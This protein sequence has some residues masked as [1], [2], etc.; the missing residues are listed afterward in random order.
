MRDLE[1]ETLCEWEMI[2]TQSDFPAWSFT[3]PLGFAH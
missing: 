2:N 3:L 1:G